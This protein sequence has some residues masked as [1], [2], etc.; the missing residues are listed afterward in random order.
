MRRPS[1]PKDMSA[2]SLMRYFRASGKPG[3]MM[4]AE[5]DG[6]LWVTDSYMAAR[7]SGS[8]PDAFSALLSLYNL[9]LEPMVC[10]VAQTIIRTDQDPPPI[11]RLLKEK[12][13]QKLDRF[14]LGNAPVLVPV[15]GG[16]SDLSEV[17]VAGTKRVCLD[18]S[19]RGM[20]DRLSGE[21]DWFVTTKDNAP[22]V[23]MAGKTPVGLA[24]PVRNLAIIA[25]EQAA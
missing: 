1:I 17:W 24:M 19:A 12:T 7:L 23:K 10:H 13:T 18:P 5:H 25:D 22:L 15:S 9:T 4:F 14:L 11:E 20:A 2:A 3:R 21:G 8:A 16:R 6:A